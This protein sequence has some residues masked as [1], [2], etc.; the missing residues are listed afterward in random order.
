[1][2][3]YA[4]IRNFLLRFDL[5]QFTLYLAAIR[6]NPMNSYRDPFETGILRMDTECKYLKWATVNPTECSLVYVSLYRSD[7]T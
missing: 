1:M 5:L 4:F 7:I 3:S 6:E 2:N